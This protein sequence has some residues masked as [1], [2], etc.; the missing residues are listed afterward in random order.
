MKI[1]IGLARLAGAGFPTAPRRRR[2][3]TPRGDAPERRSPATAREDR[4]EA[5]LPPAQRSPGDARVPSP[6]ADPAARA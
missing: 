6:S 1:P 2:L 3:R 5:P 4:G